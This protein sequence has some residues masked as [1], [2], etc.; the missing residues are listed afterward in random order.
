M[1]P[2]NK[3]IKMIAI[4]SAIREAEVEIKRVDAPAVTAPPE[5]VVPPEGPKE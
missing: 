5:A 2:Q 3:H 1:R 4:A